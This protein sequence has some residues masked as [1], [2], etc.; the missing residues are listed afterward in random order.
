MA[1]WAGALPF[2]PEDLD[3][4]DFDFDELLCDLDDLDFTL[5]DEPPVTYSLSR[6]SNTLAHLR[7]DEVEWSQAAY[8]E[9]SGDQHR[10]KR[11]VVLVS[12]RLFRA[13]YVDWTKLLGHLVHL[14]HLLNLCRDLHRSSGDLSILS[15]LIFALPLDIRVAYATLVSKSGRETG[16]LDG[17]THRQ[18]LLFGDNIAGSLDSIST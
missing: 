1:S 8:V 18:R 14:V 17:N 6:P 4:F 13:L 12:S 7:A 5:D 3:G 2:P 15:R 10:S 16:R 9:K 11:T